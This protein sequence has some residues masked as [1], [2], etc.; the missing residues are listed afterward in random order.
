MNKIL[1]IDKP[2]D[3]T[4]FDVVAKLRG[5][6]KERRIGHA[7]TLDPMATGVLPIFTGAATKFIDLL[8]CTDKKYKASFRLGIV[9]DTQD[10]TGTVIQKSEAFE[11]GAKVS[12][13]ELKA[14]SE[15]FTGDIKQ[16]PPMYSAVKSGGR[17][18]YD[19]ARKGIEIERKPREA[20][21]AKLEITEF[22]GC[23]GIIEVDCSKG[24]YVR[25]LVHDIGTALGPGAVLTSLRRTKSGCFTLNESITL[26][27]LENL[28]KQQET[29]PFIPVDSPFSGYAKIKLNEIQTRMF[30]NG[31]QLDVNRIAGVD[32]VNAR[33]FNDPIRIYSCDG[34]F[35]GLARLENETIVIVKVFRP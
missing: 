31:V 33:E 16:I 26:S 20:H 4:S 30:L 23:C 12:Y 6:L 35:S 19:L 21:I 15:K 2:P 1:V 14:V 29:V 7:G 17:K 22:D 25:T 5:I 8:P 18:L 11:N 27:K 3:F 9:T 13:S 34:K 28:T 24:C 10:I 32:S